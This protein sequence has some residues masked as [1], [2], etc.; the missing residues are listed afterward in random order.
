MT[1]Q[2]ILRQLKAIRHSSSADRIRRR[3]RTIS[4]VARETGIARETLQKTAS[5]QLPIG[6][7][8]R[9]ALRTYFECDENEGEKSSVCPGRTAAISLNIGSKMPR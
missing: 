1:D 5:G 4:D 2:D 8:T 3:S 9:T 7:R 6:P